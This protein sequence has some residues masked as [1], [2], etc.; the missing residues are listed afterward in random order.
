[1]RLD[2]TSMR[3]GPSIIDR[4]GMLLRYETTAITAFGRAVAGSRADISSSL[5]E[6][7]RSHVMRS[8]TLNIR[9]A[10]LGYRPI[11]DKP[12]AAPSQPRG[13]TAAGP[14]SIELLFAL[15]EAERY[16][17]THYRTHMHQAELDVESR[18]MIEAELMPEQLI[19]HG[20]MRNLCRSA[21]GAEGTG[22]WTDTLAADERYL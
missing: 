15:E 16:G 19:T 6:C 8:I 3:S 10:D 12:G 5:D 20:I 11:A 9:L 7:R 1:M 22:R 2:F 13:A 14:G 21:A 18:W 4:L 17:I